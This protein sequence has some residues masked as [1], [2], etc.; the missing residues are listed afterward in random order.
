MPFANAVTAYKS[1]KSEEAFR[2]DE[3][4][5][6][7]PPHFGYFGAREATVILFDDCIRTETIRD[8][9]TQ[10]DNSIPT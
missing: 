5:T 10:L 4:I 1:G 2:S 8:C 6:T 9:D 3:G 7:S